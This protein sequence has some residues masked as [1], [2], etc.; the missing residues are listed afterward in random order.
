[1]RLL[2]L[3][4]KKAD[5]ER[6]IVQHVQELAEAYDVVKAEFHAVLKGRS[7]DVHA[8]M[9][10]LRGLQGDDNPSLEGRQ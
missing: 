7:E 4:Q 6:Q 10:T 2:A 9:N 1:M 3:T 5:V 8:A